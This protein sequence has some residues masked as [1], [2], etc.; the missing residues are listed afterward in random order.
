MPEKALLDLVV[1]NVH[2]LRAVSVLPLPLSPG[3]LSSVS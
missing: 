2:L 3:G 1:S